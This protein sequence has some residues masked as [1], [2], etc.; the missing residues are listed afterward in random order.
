M[1]VRCWLEGLK[2]RDLSKDMDVDG[3]ILLKR[4]LGKWVCGCGLDSCDSG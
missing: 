1:H 2:G 4:I 3:K